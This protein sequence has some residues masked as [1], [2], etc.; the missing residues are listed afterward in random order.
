M[1]LDEEIEIKKD[2]VNPVLA[3]IFASLGLMILILTILIDSKFL[4]DPLKFYPS[5]IRFPFFYN[6]IVLFTNISLISL[7]IGVVFFL[8]FG[9]GT[10][11]CNIGT[12]GFGF[13]FSG[14]IILFILSFINYSIQS[15]RISL[16]L[17]IL[18]LLSIITSG[19]IFIFRHNVDR[20]IVFPLMPFNDKITEINLQR[21]K[22]PYGM[23]RLQQALE[24]GIRGLYLSHYFYLDK[25]K[26][27]RSKIKIIDKEHKKYLYK[28][29]HAPHIIGIMGYIF[30]FS[31]IIFFLLYFTYGIYLLVIFFIIFGSGVVLVD[32]YYIRRL[33]LRKTILIIDHWLK[34][35]GKVDLI[36]LDSEFGFLPIK[37]SLS[38]LKHILKKYETFLGAK[39]I[40][41]IIQKD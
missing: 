31:S 32:Y 18:S 1:S 23:F 13:G 36:K 17:N 35:S 27:K 6:D 9:L 28:N 5:P 22:S 4:S 38:T 26:L 37:Y 30:C 14:A 34:I 3:I 41:N 19:L 40:N 39:L 16:F 10:E 12:Y 2:W 15:E 29:V 24:R 7:L 8:W 11:Q 21:L 25:E 33:N 20:N